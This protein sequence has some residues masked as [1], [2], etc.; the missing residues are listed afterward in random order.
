MKKL[1]FLGVDGIPE[2]P[3]LE[4]FSNFY[5]NFAAMDPVLTDD[6][7]L[8]LVRKVEEPVEIESDDEDGGDA[9]E[10]NDKCL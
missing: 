4:E 2:E 7:I 10:V 8:A 5:D 6:S 9:I 1:K 3:T